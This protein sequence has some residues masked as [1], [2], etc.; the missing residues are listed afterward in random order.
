MTSRLK[1]TLEQSREEQENIKKEN[2]LL[3]QKYEDLKKKSDENNKINLNIIENLKKDNEGLK[4]DKTKLATAIVQ[5]KKITE[6]LKKKNTSK[7]EAL[8]AIKNFFMNS[9]LAKLKDIEGFKEAENNK[10]E[11]NEIK[12]NNKESEK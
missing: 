4:K 10:N 1:E 8:L 11:N 5:M 7:A 2:I 9:T 6:D 12:D 3:K